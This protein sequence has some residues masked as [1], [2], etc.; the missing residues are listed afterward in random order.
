MTQPGLEGLTRWLTDDRRLA[1]SG[2]LA[3]APVAGDASNRRYFR[4]RGSGGPCVA[5]LAPPQTE[6]NS[7]FLAV[8]ECLNSAGVR[9]PALMAADLERGYLLLE[10]LGDLLFR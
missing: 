3:L 1:P 5:V 8:Q 4:V 9:V 2:T 6:K 7:E 10:D